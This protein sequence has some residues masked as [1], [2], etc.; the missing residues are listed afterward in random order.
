MSS[1]A[2]AGQ[3]KAPPR[4]SLLSRLPGGAICAEIGV[5][6]GDFSARI[7]NVTRPRELHLIDPWAFDS[8]FPTR[9]YGG[10]KAKSQA[11][12]DAIHDSVVARFGANP[13]VTIHRRKS[14]DAAC[15]F[16][17]HTFDWV[18][19]DGDHSYAAVVQDLRV[20]RSKVKPEG[21]IAGDDLI[22]RDEFGAIPVR[23]AVEEFVIACGLDWEELP[24]AQFL[25]KR[26]R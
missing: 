2:A 11:D 3:Q 20:W 18:Y 5:W 23:R 6:R 4:A 7:L 13:A 21:W 17:D 15:A 24:G 26:S 14:A 22:W 8:D 1:P 12:M 25:I 9:W 10:K 19:I 16:A